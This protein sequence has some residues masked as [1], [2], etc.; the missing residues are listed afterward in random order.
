M[1]IAVL[2][3]PDEPISLDLYRKNITSE[4]SL[5][6]VESIEF[7]EFEPIPT[8]CDLLWEPGLCMRQLPGILK[9]SSIPIVGTMH[10]VKAF[11]L[12]IFEL[13]DNLNEQNDLV[14]LKQ[15]MIKEW[16]LFKNKVS[17]VIA[18]SKYA[19]QEV[20][21]A[22][23]LPK[24]KVQTIY[25][26]IDHNIFNINSRKHCNPKPYILHVSYDNPIKNIERL[27]R[28]YSLLSENNRPDLIAVLPGYKKNHDIK[29]INII[30]ERLTHS[31]LV[32]YY[33]GAICF[34]LPS[35]RETFG[36]PILE[37]MA[38]GCPVITSNVSGCAEVAGDASI[39]CDP[40]SVDSIKEKI[41]YLLSDEALRLTLREKGLVRSREFSWKNSAEE[42]LKVFYTKVSER[43][44]NKRKDSNPLSFF[45]KGVIP[46]CIALS[47][48]SDDV[49]FSLCGMI[50]N[51]DFNAIHVV[52]VFSV[53]SCTESDLKY[54]ID[55]ITEMRKQE[56]LYFF[57]SLDKNITVTHMDM[58]DAPLR[59]GINENQ[60]FSTPIP[61]RDCKETVNIFNHIKSICKPNVLLF[62]PLAIGGHID[63]LIVRNAAL[64]LADEGYPIVLYE[65]LPYSG[66][67]TKEQI[68]LYILK[69]ESE[70]K[71]KFSALIVNIGQ[72]FEVKIQKISTY[73]LQISDLIIGR[74]IKHANNVGNGNPSERIWVSEKA[75][76]RFK[77]EASRRK[78]MGY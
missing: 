49:A 74:I 14:N 58:L 78:R 46:E 72:A 42:L 67:I 59:L 39:L 24:E 36:I 40:R 62:A 21:R 17:V 15:K 63:H 4:L 75:H 32:Q 18:V 34:I 44:Q 53:S 6:G 33:R 11:S 55:R 41:E 57:E 54:P 13:A 64:M 48:H 25:N 56:D 5:L 37:A 68:D 61:E 29:G 66:D 7:S 8:R 38:C 71:V 1:Q 28:A 35:L 10:G 9:E 65:D 27:F 73:K 76:G 52:T 12:P 45:D 20:S 70:K 2:T 3:R 22:F 50:M 16:S 43:P 69:I 26:G 30:R 23:N 60:V 19:A 51:N 47:P 77:N 31:E